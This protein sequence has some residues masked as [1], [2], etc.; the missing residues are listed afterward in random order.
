MSGNHHANKRTISPKTFEL[1]DDMIINTDTSTDAIAAL[2]EKGID[3][4]YSTVC[5]RKNLIY[6]K[7]K[8]DSVKSYITKAKIAFNEMK[9]A[10]CKEYNGNIY[11]ADG[12]PVPAILSTN[13]TKFNVWKSIR[14][15]TKYI[16]AMYNGYEELNENTNIW[17]LNEDP[18]DTR[19]INLHI[20]VNKSYRHRRHNKIEIENICRIFA[21]EKGDPLK[22]WQRC[23]DELGDFI[24]S[25]ILSNLRTKQKYGDISDNYF[26]IND[27]KQWYGERNYLSTI[28]LTPKDNYTGDDT[29]YAEILEKY[30][31]TN[32]EIPLQDKEFILKNFLTQEYGM[33][34]LLFTDATDLKYAIDS[35]R[36]KLKDKGI[37]ISAGYIRGIININGG[38]IELGG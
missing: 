38:G 20:S 34:G 8:S 15:P 6:G 11:Y 27:V 18:R 14:I 12:T 24:T 29:K 30:A 26:T 17:N 9:A 19:I 7:D 25:A 1:I 28:N 2:H 33:D 4:S 35:I 23:V 10:G 3:V 22:T 5:R 31:F 13:F 37:N 16:V 21:E 32:K 36:N